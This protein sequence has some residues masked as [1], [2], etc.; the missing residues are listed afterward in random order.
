[1]SDD[2]AKGAPAARENGAG[3]TDAEA[4]ERVLDGHRD[5]FAV[6]IRR[7]QERLHRFALGMVK[8]PDAASDLVQ[9]SFVTAYR[10]LESCRDP[11]SFGVWVRQIVRNRCRDF[12]KNI[13]RGHEPLD[14]HPTL[15]SGFDGPASELER[16]E[17]RESLRSA[18]DELPDDQRE[19]FLL[20]HL[21]GRT[22]REMTD[23]LDASTS[24]LKMR[25]HRARETLRAILDE[26]IPAAM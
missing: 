13:R 10:K 26:Q 11:S 1:M 6:L 9:E 4:V 2:A 7:H 22:Y 5:A 14:A 19:A 18:L 8:D 3:P 25:V 20:K 17:L 15:V 24:A 21:D 23:I 12:L 16:T